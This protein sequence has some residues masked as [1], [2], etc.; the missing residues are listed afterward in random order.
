[1]SCDTNMI[2]ASRICPL[3]AT[4]ICLCNIS[5]SCLVYLVQNFGLLQ[6]WSV[7]L[8]SDNYVLIIPLNWVGWASVVRLCMV[9]PPLFLCSAGH[10]L[11]ITGTPIGLIQLTNTTMNIFPNI[12]SKYTRACITACPALKLASD[13]NNRHGSS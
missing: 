2:H 6:V 11:A 10:S 1:M 7:F 5:A 9:R 8:V 4:A 13:S 12:T 3:G